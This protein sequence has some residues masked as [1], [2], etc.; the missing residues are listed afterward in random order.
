MQS[1]ALPSIWDMGL[2]T[3][4]H[5]IILTEEIRERTIKGLLQL[6]LED[7]WGSR[8]GSKGLR[9]CLMDA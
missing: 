9:R 8:I 6:I 1:A 3:F 5:H 4:R 7:R 2:D